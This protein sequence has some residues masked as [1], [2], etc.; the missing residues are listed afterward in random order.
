MRRTGMLFLTMYIVVHVSGQSANRPLKAQEIP[1]YLD[2]TMPVVERVADLVGR[3]TL[4]E[5]VSQMVHNAP[6]I[7]RL[8]IPE[9][10]W[11]NEALHGVARNG[12]ATVFPQSI[13]LAA[14]WDADLIYRSA[15]VIS[16]EARAKYNKAIRKN[17]RGIYQGITLFSPNI[18]IFR[19][20]RWGRG[21]ETYGEDPYLTGEIGVQFIRGLQGDDARYLKTIATPKHLAV[22]SGPEPERHSFNAVAG[23][24]DLRETYLPHFKKCVVEGRAYAVM[25]AYNRF[26]GEACCGSELLIRDI[27]RGEWGFE[28]LMV[29]DCWAVSDIYNNH[30]I[31]G[32]PEEA[33]AIALLAGTDLE[34]GNAFPSLTNAA[35]MG[36]ISEDNIDTALHRIFTARFRL[37]MFDP[38]E[39]VPFSG[40]DAVD[41]PEH[42][43]IA[44]EAARK[45]I[46]LLKNESARDDTWPGPLLPLRK[47]LKTLAVI[48]PN[49][50][51]LESLLGNY[52]G[53]P[54][55][56]VTPLKGIRNKL[57]DTRVLY[58][59]GSRLVENVPSFEIIGPSFLYTSDER[60]QEGLTGEY[61]H[62]PDMSGEPGFIRIDTT[63]EFYW[64]E[65]APG[66]EMDPDSFS[67][68]WT[69]VL[70]PEFTGT[71][72]L[73]GYGYNRFNIYL[74]DSLVVRF[75][76]EFD[77]VKSYAY[78][79]LEKGKTYP[80]RVEF[81]KTQ[82]YSFMQLI[83][84]VPDDA[85]ERRAIDAARQ[86][87]AV[88]MVMGLSPRL[89]GEA[90]N[91][92][93]EGFRG[94]DRTTLDL[95]AV[96]SQLIRKIHAVGKPIVLVLLSGSA[97]SVRW[98]DEHIPAII[99]AWYPGQSGGDAIADVIFGDY[100]PAGRL[101]V[102]FYRSVDQL[103]DFRS[104]AMSN[105]TYRYFEGTPL[106]PFG[107]GLSY[108]TFAYGEPTLR[109][110]T[111]GAGESTVLSVDIKNEGKREGDEVVQLY[112]R[113]HD[114]D[115]AIRTLRGFR[116]TT[117]APGETATVG[118]EISPE[119]LSRWVEGKGETTEPGDYTLWVGSSSSED[120]LIPITLKVERESID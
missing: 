108:T 110:K 31:A 106:Y 26:R 111:I 28:G 94:G 83:W 2:H 42:R 66:T 59:R 44:L 95:P 101:P 21:M 109:R 20:P 53:F 112:I 51:N 98:E 62:T 87:D 15:T 24:Y 77:P 27:L 85:Y 65:D 117:L 46:V 99:A 102:T 88:V 4:E 67:V 1:P 47:D 89:E 64:L 22:H 19:D 11:W 39:L 74:G 80:I 37:G 82:R 10:N 36:L 73:G 49:A 32:S 5:K 68:R 34:C 69:G 81:F 92:E 18:N 93:V 43:S 63:I 50:D 70:V 52:H 96:Q 116:R 78:V 48:G 118:F 115:K 76:G 72:T 13:G 16:D 120:D 55:D 8:G 41:T 97:L 91:V 56:P 9:Y 60:K 84:D 119:T 3:M 113:A 79:T 7:E 58:E 35:G 100:N 75:D 12:L 33:S 71:Y 38:P 23:E 25:C 6:A 40:L 14:T 17:Q 105:R 30:R 103:P 57:P 114:D 54:S 29:S 90:L 107:Y 61:F 86:A 104:Y 45:S